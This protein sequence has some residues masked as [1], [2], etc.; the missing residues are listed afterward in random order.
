MQCKD[1]PIATQRGGPPTPR[2]LRLL[3]EL[4]SFVTSAFDEPVDTPCAEPGNWAYEA[5]ALIAECR[6]EDPAAT[7]GRLSPKS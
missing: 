1:V 5:L 2:E 6:G 4:E 7:V 3:A